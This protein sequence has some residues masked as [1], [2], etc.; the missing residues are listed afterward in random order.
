LIPS[1]FNKT[2][3]T[4]AR[5]RR[6]RHDIVADILKVSKDGANKTKIIYKANLSFDQSNTYIDLLLEKG[7]LQLGNPHNIYKTTDRGLIF[8][9]RY[10]EMIPLL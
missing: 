3:K 1:S 4:T 6:G 7:L 10:Q 8:L 9:K 5:R 2:E